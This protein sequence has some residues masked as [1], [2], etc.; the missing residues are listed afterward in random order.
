MAGQSDD[1]H[2]VA[3]VLAA[4]LSADARLA[5]QLQDLVLPLQVA[6]SASVFVAAGG[7]RVQVPAVCEGDVEQGSAVRELEGK[8][9]GDRFIG[10]PLG[11]RLLMHDA[12]VQGALGAAV[13]CVSC[14][15]IVT[16]CKQGV[17]P[18]Q[19]AR[20]PTLLR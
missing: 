1:T 12:S 6:E 10:M 17:H 7:Q 18:V 4:E 3:E 8:R 20:P 13:A 15:S 5:R 2:I 16:G 11:R 14:L 9:A 19:P